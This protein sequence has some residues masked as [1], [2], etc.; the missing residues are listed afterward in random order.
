MSKFTPIPIP[1]KFAFAICTILLVL[2]AGCVPL[3]VEGTPEIGTV[4]PA[5]AEPVVEPVTV[6]SDTIQV[7]TATITTPSLVLRRFPTED[8]PALAGLEEGDT[9]KVIGISTDGTWVRLEALDAPTGAGW[10]AARFVTVSGDI[11]NVPITDG[12][13]AATVRPTPPPGGAVVVTDGTRLRVRAEPDPDATIVVYAYDGEIYNV[14]ETTDDGEWTRIDAIGMPDGGWV[15]SEFLAFE[16]DSVAGDG[17]SDTDAADTDADDTE[18]DD[19]E[20]E[21]ATDEDAAADEDADTD[22]AATETA[23]A[24]TEADDTEVDDTEAE[25]ATDEDADSADAESSETESLDDTADTDSAETER[26]VPGVGEAVVNT[27]G[28]RL[29]VRSEPTTEATIISYV[30]DGELYTVL[31]FNEDGTWALIDVTDV[32]EGGWVSTE[33]LEFGSADETTDNT[34]LTETEAVTDTAP[35][36]DSV[37]IT[38][39]TAADDTDAVTSTTTTTTTVITVGELTETEPFTDST[40][41]QVGGEVTEI[42]TPNPGEAVVFTDG[43]RLRVRSE[44]DTDAQIVAYVYNGEVYNVLEV[45]E[46]GQWIRIDVEG[47]ENGGWV[48]DLYVLT[49]DQ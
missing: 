17:T 18:S 31:D 6:D 30:Y 5:T 43:T 49:A 35:I 23:E 9:Y 21:A 7:A 46:D 1:N 22:S 12:S 48:A 3:Q 41:G 44:P 34:E 29:R 39:E 33:F 20:A 19:T 37:V 14:L 26:P 40:G 13:G 32:P 25:A 4:P 15:A 36:T 8:S 28:T 47:L 16:G 10:V 11:T 38:E 2:T 24:D 45:S 27:D 42:P